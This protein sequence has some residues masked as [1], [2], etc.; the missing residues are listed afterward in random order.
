M[1]ASVQPEIF[2]FTGELFTH[3]RKAEGRKFT[4]KRAR[5]YAAELVLGLEYMH[6][7]GIIYRYFVAEAI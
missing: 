7:N 3:L 2:L 1:T 4:E 5:F 6:N